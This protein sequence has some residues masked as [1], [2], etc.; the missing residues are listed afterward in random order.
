MSTNG[1][2]TSGTSVFQDGGSGNDKAY[3]IVTDTSGNLY[4]G[5][6]AESRL[7]GNFY[8]QSFL[9]KLNPSLERQWTRQPD[10]NIGNSITIDKTNRIYLL[11]KNNINKFNNDGETFW[12]QSVIA[13]YNVRSEVFTDIAPSKGNDGNIY[14]SL[15]TEIN[16][17]CGNAN[18]NSINLPNS[19]N[20]NIKDSF[21]VK[22]DE[23]GQRKWTEV[24]GISGSETIINSITTELNDDIFVTGYTS[25]NLEGISNSGSYDLFIKKFNTSGVKQWTKLLGSSSKESGNQ[26]ITDDSGNVYVTGFTEGILDGGNLKGSRDMLIAKVNSSGTFQ[27]VKQIGDTYSEG[28]DLSLD[29]DGYIYILGFTNGD[30]DG[31]SNIGS[32]DIFVAKYNPL[33]GNKLWSKQYGSSFDDYGSGI[34]IDTL[35]NVYIT[36]YTKGGMYGNVS[37]GNFDIFV[38]K[39][40]TDGIIQ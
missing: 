30:F 39:L 33:D 27:W 14:I 31:N 6:D 12:T 29:S 24:I 28:K 4:V 23:G 20:H 17:C 37:A 34:A 10:G 22:F 5:G 19:Y 25:G 36:G 8:N 21:L 38:M 13:P 32:A 7:S 1:F 26:I 15:N 16:S 9:L 3:K 40:N 18:V 35:N 2:R 11:S